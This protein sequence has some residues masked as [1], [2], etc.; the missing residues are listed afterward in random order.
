M[1]APDRDL[2]LRL[3]EEGDRLN[4]GPWRDHSLAVARA[5]ELLADQLP[6]LD[7][8]MAYVL[9]SLHDIGRRFGVTGMRHVYDGYLF[10]KEMGFDDAAQ[11]NLTHSFPIKQVQAVFG[12][13]D[14]TDDELSFI[15]SYLDSVEYTLYDRL[16]QLCDSLALPE[17]FC[18]IEKR[19][20]DV[21]LRYGVNEF[22]V[23]KW[24]AYLEIKQE[25]ERLL[26][27]SIYDVLPGAVEITFQKRLV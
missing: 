21:A 12:K 18:L 27:H 14:C 15:Q 6:G 24:K 22:T 19:F 9:G 17:G 2:A 7:K 10:L 13:W 25:I 4:P 5:A 26:G 1:K 23:T 20:V 8:N 16:I 11:I 3:L